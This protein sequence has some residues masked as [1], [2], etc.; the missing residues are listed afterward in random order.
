MRVTLVLLLIAAALAISTYF[1]RNQKISQ[2]VALEQGLQLS[3]YEFEN[4]LQLKVS[5]PFLSA[6]FK[7]VDDVWMIIE[8]FSARADLSELHGLYQSIFKRKADS[9]F[10][11]T[12]T[13]EDYGLSNSPQRLAF[14][15]SGSDN[16]FIIGLKK[17]FGETFYVKEQRTNKIFVMPF[18]WKSALEKPINDFIEKQIVPGSPSTWSRIEFKGSHSQFVLFKEANVWKLENPPQCATE[19]GINDWLREL[20]YLR[21][22]KIEAVGDESLKSENSTKLESPT[23]V[24]NITKNTGSVVL[25]LKIKNEKAERS[26]G[27]AS[28]SDQNVIHQVFSHSIDKVNLDLRQFC[29]TAKTK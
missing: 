2:E 20:M 25:K 7:K 13:A 27:Y 8:P 21:S 19:E 26:D 12:S 10:S 22:I 3:P 28:V 1:I 4:I 5:S 18:D 14:L 24:L 6:H 11:E 17:G 9:A 16:E 15:L 29:K 23:C